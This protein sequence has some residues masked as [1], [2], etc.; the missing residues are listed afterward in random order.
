ME[1]TAE[2]LAPVGLFVLLEANT[3]REDDVEA[4]LRGALALVREEPATTTWFAVRMGPAIFA[5]FATFADEAGRQAHLAG[6]ASAALE[7]KATELLAE[8]PAVGRVDVLAAR[9]R[10]LPRDM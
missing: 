3:G 10:G 7:A 9:L 8:P 1:T 2:E 5:I 4:L 6:R